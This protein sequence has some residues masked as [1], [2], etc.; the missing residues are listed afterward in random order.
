MNRPVILVDL[1]NVVYDWTRAIAEFL[2]INGAFRSRDLRA[3]LTERV[4]EYVSTEDN[5]TYAMQLY[6]QWAV[7]DDWGI[8]KGEFMRWW[9]LGVEQGWVYGLGPEIPGAR[10][11]LWK[12]SDAEWHIHIAT[13]RLTKFGLHDKI[14]E[15]TARW[16]R[17]H[18]IPYR[19]LSLVSD[20]KRILADAI[21][22]DKAENMNNY[23]HKRVFHFGAPHN[24]STLIWDDIVGALL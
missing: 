8:P 1:D 18:N 3:R 6:S 7:W 19:D 17:D 14:A 5:V 9:R 23:V 12:L 22:D 13:S 11:A 15:N 20:K 2:E 21:V 16:L 4:G 24:D 10:R